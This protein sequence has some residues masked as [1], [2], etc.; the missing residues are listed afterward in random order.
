M[1]KDKKSH[2]KTINLKYQLQCGI[3]SL[4]YLMDDIVHQIFNIQHYFDY[5]IK[6]HQKVTANSP[7][8]T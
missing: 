1:E 4:N 3:K 2:T 7:I 5:I 8:R 6:K